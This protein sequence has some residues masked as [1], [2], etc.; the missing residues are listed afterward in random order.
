MEIGRVIADARARAHLSARELASRAGTSHATLLGYESGRIDPSTGVA[1]RILRA[2]GCRVR[3]EVDPVVRTV[4]G[5]PAGEELAEVLELAEHLPQRRRSRRL[6][7][8]IFPGR[9]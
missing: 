7:A 1:E 5:R 9:P 6:D 8:P 3:V 2:A 4:T